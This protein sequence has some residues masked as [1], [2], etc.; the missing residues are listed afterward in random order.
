[1]SLNPPTKSLR[2]TLGFLACAAWSMTLWAA[3]PA[4]P[5]PYAELDS[6][7]IAELAALLPESPRGFGEPA[8]NAA[9]WAALRAR[10]QCQITIRSQ[11][12]KIGLPV[13][14][15]N[16]DRYLEY[17]RT[18]RRP[19]GQKM[20]SDRHERL[21]NLVWAECLE[22]QGRFLPDLENLLSEF[23]REPTWTM[24]AH[25]GN[26]DNF[27]GKKYQV[28]L[29]AASFAHEVAQAL[30]LLEGKLNPEIRSRTVGVMEQRI[31][32]PLRQSIRTGKDHWWLRAEMN[33][34]P[35]CLAGAVGAALTVLPDRDDRAVF[36]AAAEHYSRNYLKGFSTEGY[37]GEG[38]GYWNM[39]MTAY[40]GLREQLW[41]NTRGRL[42]LLA[43]PKVRAAALFGINMEI[44][45]GV[46]PA[47][48]DCRW[49]TRPSPEV[50][51]YLSRALG[52]GLK[53]YEAQWDPLSQHDL[54]YG[55][56]ENFSNSLSAAAT[57]ATPETPLEPHYFFAEPGILVC[58]SFPESGPAFGAVL[59]GGD[60]DEPHNHNDIGSFTLVYG[61]NGFVVD[62]GGPLVYSK[63]TF[64]KERY[65]A[66]KL[67]SSLGHGVPVV[68]G[69][70]QI[71]GKT[72]RAKIVRSEFTADRDELAL[73]L[74]SAY[75]APELISLVRTFVFD[76]KN[77]ELRVTDD[78]AFR[79]PQAFEE[80]LTTR[81]ACQTGNPNRIELSAGGLAVLAEITAPGPLQAS[82]ERIEEDCPAFDRIGLRLAAPVTTGTVQMRFHLATH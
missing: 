69:R 67:F 79:S 32:G 17:S 15:W 43:D 26:L 6:G 14:A 28:D 22:N 21:A 37:L 31:F 77:Q 20:M 45:N 63:K 38:L 34:N 19:D 81:V 42:D 23:D 57:V 50:L 29:G 48:A 73:D 52:L 82:T 56:L 44:V 49:G 62:P 33:W 80:A 2:Q 3:G 27:H 1:M 41:Q 65:T 53:K 55:S 9:A 70:A 78:F 66:F 12:K 7:R 75:D 36:A 54:V 8:T 16:D 4:V 24:P 64:S 39:G 68:A 18:G 11:A 13:P 40:I 76:R 30:W 72:A 25:D 74:T 59:K 51:N 5:R 46:Y 10:P 35:F 60:N 47:I 61:T 71:P 58:R